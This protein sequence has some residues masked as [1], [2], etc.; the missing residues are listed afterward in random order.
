MKKEKALVALF[1]GKVLRGRDTELRIKGG[2]LQKR[3]LPE[4]S[5]YNTNTD[6]WLWENFEIE[7]NPVDF[8]TAWADMFINGS[9]YTVKHIENEGVFHIEYIFNQVDSVDGV[10]MYTIYGKTPYKASISNKLIEGE[11]YKV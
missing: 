9:K 8:M 3:H 4:G 11:W 10:L 2:Q 7:A 1:D 5:W 6:G